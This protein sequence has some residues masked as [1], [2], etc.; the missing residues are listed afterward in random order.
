MCMC[1]RL[2]SISSN[3]EVVDNAEE[4]AKGTMSLEM[5]DEH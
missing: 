5:L 4:G 1:E 3:G 2:W